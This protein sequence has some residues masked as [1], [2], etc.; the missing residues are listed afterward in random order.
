M[1]LILLKLAGVMDVEL[2]TETYCIRLEPNYRYLHQRLFLDMTICFWL[3]LKS[4]ESTQ[5]HYPLSSGT[6]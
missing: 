4:E 3:G 6:S 2:A 1:Y 5:K